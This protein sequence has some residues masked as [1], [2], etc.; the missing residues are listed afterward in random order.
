MKESRRDEKAAIITALLLPNEKE[1]NN[2]HIREELTEHA[3]K[4][5][6]RA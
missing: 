3:K 2:L 5:L 4:V 1:I 6:V